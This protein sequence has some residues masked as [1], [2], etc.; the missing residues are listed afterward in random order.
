ME[1]SNK[2]IILLYIRF[3]DAPQGSKCKDFDCFSCVCVNAI[4]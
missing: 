4:A 3:W 1:I 2:N